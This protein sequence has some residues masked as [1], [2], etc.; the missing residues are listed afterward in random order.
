[1]NMKTLAL[2][3]AIASPAFTA[4]PALT[5]YHQGF[6]VVRDSLALD[7]KAG[8]NNVSFGGATARLEADSVILRDAAGKAALQIL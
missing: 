2:L 6:A 3:L 7:L 1:M 5:I 8:V 4:E